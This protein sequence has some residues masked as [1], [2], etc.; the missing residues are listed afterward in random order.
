MTFENPLGPKALLGLPIGQHISFKFK[1][2]EGKDVIRSY[3][4]ITG[5][6]LPGS[7]TFVIKV[8]K[9][10]VHPKFPDGGE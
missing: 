5:D 1:D 6:E 2:D 10:G 9:A 8:Y 3:T 7:V 4:P